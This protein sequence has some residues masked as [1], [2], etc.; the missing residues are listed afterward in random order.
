MR[1]AAF[2]LTVSAALAQNTA[3]SV[4]IGPTLPVL[5]NVNQIFFK[6]TAA[7]GLYFCTAPNTWQA[8]AFVA[9]GQITLILSGTCPLGFS[10]VTALDGKTVIGTLAAHGD[11]GT[12]GGSDSI[13]PAGTVS[14]PTISGTTSAV[15]AGTPA[16][17]VSPI[18]ATALAADLV[19]TG[20]TFKV[21]D[22]AHTHPAPTFTGSALATHSHTQG[23]LANSAPTFAGS[24]FD[25]RSAFVKVI[26]CSKD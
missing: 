5:C 2:L 3:T 25:N 26:F 17:T 14:T 20:A 13:T 16:G 18:T 6:T 8:T 9:P 1:L 12:T 22:N 15:S 4:V 19:L 23:T 21:A 7:G 10:E 24:S 11:V